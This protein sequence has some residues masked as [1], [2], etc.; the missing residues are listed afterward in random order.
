MHTFWRSRDAYNAA[1]MNMY[2]LIHLQ[3]AMAE[4][5]GVAVGQYLDFSDSYHVYNRNSKQ[6]DKF[7]DSVEK[8]K[9]TGEL[10]MDS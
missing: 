7:I 2:A 1:F 3:K 9:G 8:L 6:L 5:I 4:K 10:S